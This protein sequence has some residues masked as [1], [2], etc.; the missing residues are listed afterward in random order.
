[1]LNIKNI[2]IINKYGLAHTALSHSRS[3]FLAPT[4]GSCVT[5]CRQ[6]CCVLPCLIDVAVFVHQKSVFPG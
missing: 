4:D 5:L 3:Y 6:L 2:V 1:M